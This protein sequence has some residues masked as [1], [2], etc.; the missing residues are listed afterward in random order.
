MINPKRWL[1]MPKVI[2]ITSIRLL[3]LFLLL[4]DTRIETMFD[5]NDMIIPRPIRSSRI[6]SLLRV[7]FILKER[8]R[9]ETGMCSCMCCGVC[10]GVPKLFF[11][12]IRSTLGTIVQRRCS[13]ELADTRWWKSRELPVN[14]QRAPFKACL[15]LCSHPQSNL[16]SF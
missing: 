8:G 2:G 6:S 14:S 1:Q 5:R 11:F 16:S 3:R 7:G 13:R 12:P 4:N 9:R 15:T 10:C